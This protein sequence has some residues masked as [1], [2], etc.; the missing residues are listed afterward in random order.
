M[1]RNTP[2]AP[3]RPVSNS[4]G[5]SAMPRDVPRMT[6]ESSGSRQE[7]AHPIESITGRITPQSSRALNS[8]TLSTRACASSVCGLIQPTSGYSK[9]TGGGRHQAYSSSEGSPDTILRVASRYT[10]PHSRVGGRS[11][12]RRK[13]AGAAPASSSGGDTAN[14]PRT[15]V[16]S[17]RYRT[18]NSTKP[19]ASGSWPRSQSRSRSRSIDRGLFTGMLPCQFHS[20]LRLTHTTPVCALTTSSTQ[21]S[22]YGS[23]LCQSATRRPLALTILRSTT[24]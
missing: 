15:Q 8:M 23:E 14:Q 1:S 4:L 10:A 2:R 7:S 5:H 21:T 24:A 16:S 11:L 20:G 17:G 12:L 22:T 9:W 6:S 19:R 3:K 18:G 13:R